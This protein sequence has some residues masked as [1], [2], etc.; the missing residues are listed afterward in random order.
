MVEWVKKLKRLLYKRGHE[1]YFEDFQIVNLMIF[2]V[3]DIA[4]D[5]SIP[6]AAFSN[7]TN[8][9]KNNVPVISGTTGWLE[10]YD[11]ALSICNELKG[12]FYLCIQ[13]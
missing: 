4:I 9:F 10:R 7:I 6:S 2:T 3:A 5:F 8:C 12:S 1:N 13:F 11:E